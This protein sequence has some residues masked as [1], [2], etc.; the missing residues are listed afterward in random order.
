[1]SFAYNPTQGA[2]ELAGPADDV[3]AGPGPASAADQDFEPPRARVTARSGG[4]EPEEPQ[5]DSATLGRKRR[6]E[7]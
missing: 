4:A 5:G 6:N 1:M 3:A 2:E 7:Q